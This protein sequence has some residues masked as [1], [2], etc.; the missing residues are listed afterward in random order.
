MRRC[1]LRAS[2]AAGTSRCGGRRGASS[3]GRRRSSPVP[4]PTPRSRERY[5]R[6]LARGARRRRAALLLHARRRRTT[7]TSCCATR[8]GRWRAGTA[9][10]CAAARA[11]LPDETTLCATCWMHGVFAAQLTIGNTS[12]PQAFLRL[13]RSLQHHPRERAAHPGRAGEGWRLLAVPSAFEIGLSDCRWIY[14]LDDRTV[15]VRARRGRR[16]AGDAVAGHGRGRA[17]P[18]PRLRPPGPRRARIRPCAAGS[19]STPPRKRFAF[20]P[21]PARSGA[22]TIRRPSITWSPARRT[23]SRRSAATNCSTRTAGRAAAPTSRC[24]R[25]RRGSSASP[26]SAR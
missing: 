7:A 2:F 4:S 8:S 22:S 18:L 12:L 25:G 3:K 17:V 11:M 23:R 9:R 16:R 20:R 6:A 24:G 14:R 26:S 13:A 1:W 10:S 21:D 5:P 19:R 15:T